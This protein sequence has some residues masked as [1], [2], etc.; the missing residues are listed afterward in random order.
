MCDGPVEQLLLRRNFNE[1]SFLHNGDAVA[2]MGNDSEIM[3][4]KYIGQAF[5]LSAG[6]VSSLTPNPPSS[7]SKLA[8]GADK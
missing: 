7:A 8:R 6:A 5:A 2:K 3:A 4:D 1:T